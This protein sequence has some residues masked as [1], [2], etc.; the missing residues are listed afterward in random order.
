MLSS[1]AVSS[2]TQN[3]RLVVE[4]AVV[5]GFA[6]GIPSSTPIPLDITPI[7]A[8]GKGDIPICVCPGTGS[9]MPI[10]TGA[11]VVFIHSSPGAS[12]SAEFRRVAKSNGNSALVTYKSSVIVYIDGRGMAHNLAESV[13]RLEEE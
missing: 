6:N 11:G 2:A 13:Q 7:P 1:R 10:D 5:A 8:A 9:G 3:H 4:A 12:H